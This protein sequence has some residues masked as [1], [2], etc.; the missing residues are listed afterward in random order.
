[1]NDAIF[2]LQVGLP[3]I[4]M[5]LGWGFGRLAE[6]RHY[7]SIRRREKQF[8]HIP[9]STE[10][11]LYDANL[12]IADAHLVNGS[13]VISVDHFKRFLAWLRGLFGGELHSYS[14]LIDRAR[15]EATLRMKEKFPDADIFLNFRFET[16][17]ISGSAGRSMGTV[18][19]LAYAT[20]VQFDPPLR[21]PMV[22][23]DETLA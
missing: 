13:V 20:A 10:R 2:F 9:V 16:S 21:A 11:N 1:M 14:S 22:P 5:V 3:L 12:K 4:L 18:E 8:L 7:R 15:R 19:V 23:T 6:H 17:T